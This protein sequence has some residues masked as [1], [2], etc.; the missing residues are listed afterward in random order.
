MRRRDADPVDERGRLVKT[1]TVKLN[2][3][4]DDYPTALE[5]WIRVKTSL[6]TLTVE[7]E[8]HKTAR[9]LATVT[10]KSDRALDIAGDVADLAMKLKRTP[11]RAADDLETL[12]SDLEKLRPEYIAAHETFILARS[13]EAARIAQTFR[14]RHGDAVAAIISAIEALA[15]ALKFERDVRDEFAAVSPEPRSHLLPDISSD[16]NQCDLSNWDG[17]AARWARRVRTLLV[18]K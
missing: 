17:Q 13:A 16:L 6:N 5:N 14:P 7:I 11:L 4:A 10:D 8:R 3:V 15:A 18:K 12:R 2:E 1:A 9:Y